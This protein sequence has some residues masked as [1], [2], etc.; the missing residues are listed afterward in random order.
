MGPRVYKLHRSMV[1]VSNLYLNYS[2]CTNKKVKLIATS[3]N[4]NTFL[5][6]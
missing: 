4:T 1:K 5:A 6:I 2:N 3:S